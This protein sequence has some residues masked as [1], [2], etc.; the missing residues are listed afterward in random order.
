MIGKLYYNDVF[1]KKAK[2]YFDN[3][4]LYTVILNSDEVLKR[5]FV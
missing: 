4:A 3:L 2:Q 5:A 1:R